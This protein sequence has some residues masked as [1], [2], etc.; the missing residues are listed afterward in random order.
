MPKTEKIRSMFDAIAPSYDSLNH[1]FSLGADRHWRRRALREINGTDILDMACGTG[2]F[3]IDEAQRIPGARVTGVDLSDGMLAVMRE[4]VAAK[5]LEDRIS[6]EQGDCL[7]LRFED[8]TFDA[9]TIGFGIRNFEDRE[10]CLKELVRV[11]RDD[12]RLVILE[13]SVP[14]NPVLRWFYCLYFKHFM[15]IVGGLVSGDK[16]AYRYLPAS[17][18]AF[19]GPEEWMETM[20]GA[21]YRDVTHRSFTFGLCRMYVGVK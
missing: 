21:G 16:A 9:V 15:P 12:G 18:L 2:D 4:K 11:L 5:G 6:C 13:L 3:A 7:H 14:R 19:P 1:I 8:G 10:A 20:R 17:V